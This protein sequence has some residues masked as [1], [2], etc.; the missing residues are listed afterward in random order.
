MNFKEF[1]LSIKGII[2][3]I[4]PHDS[5]IEHE[6]LRNSY[7]NWWTEDPMRIRGNWFE[8]FCLLHEL[9]PI[10]MI[11]CYGKREE[12]QYRSDRLNVFWT[13]ENLFDSAKQWYG[14]YDD[15]LVEEVDLALG[16]DSISHTKYLRFPIWIQYLTKGRHTDKGLALLQS[17]EKQHDPNRPIFCS[18]VARHDN[19][20]SGQ[21]LRIKC[22][23]AIETVGY[24]VNFE[25]K[26]NN[27]S[28]ILQSGYNNKLGAY[29]KDCRFNI[30]LEN[31][32]GPGYTTEKLWNSLRAGAVPIYWGESTPE[33]EILSQDCFL[34]YDPQNPEHLIEN[35]RKLETSEQLRSNFINQKKL[36]PGA[37]DWMNEKCTLLL[38]KLS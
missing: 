24:K 16:F 5:I 9:P 13:G 8:Q 30:C 37:K 29:L 1:K 19:R 3:K 38:K 15:H 31:S 14:Q 28:Q 27:N 35:V 11:S 33:A 23:D 20:G 10:H 25:G 6:S 26:L 17:L 2:R 12:V 4:K 36:L 32:Q 22:A 18:L 7:S 34:T 21:G